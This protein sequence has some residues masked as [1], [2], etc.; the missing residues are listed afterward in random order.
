[1][2]RRKPP[3]LPLLPPPLPRLLLQKP[4][5]P[6]L[7]P[8]RLPTLLLRPPLLRRLLQPPRLL[9]PHRLLPASN[10]GLRYEKSRPRAAFFLD[11]TLSAAY[12]R[13]LSSVSRMALTVSEVSGWPLASNTVSDDLLADSPFTTMR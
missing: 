7:Q 3:R 5:R 2:A 12:C 6:L 9:P 13:S 4:L 1:M 8:P 10:P 11:A